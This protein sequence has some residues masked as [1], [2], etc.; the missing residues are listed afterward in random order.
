MGKWKVNGEI[1]ELENV[2]QDAPKSVLYPE[3]F[4][5]R[6]DLEVKFNAKRLQEGLKNN[7]SMQQGQQSQSNGIPTPEQLANIQHAKPRSEE[8]VE[9]YKRQVYGD[10][11]PQGGQAQPQPQAQ[12]PQ[13]QPSGIPGQGAGLPWQNQSIQ[14]QYGSFNAKARPGKGGN[15][16]DYEESPEQ[17]GKNL[18]ERQGAS[19]KGPEAALSLLPVGKFVKGGWAAKAA[20]ETA[21]QGGLAALFNPETAAKSGT[22]AA[23]T[24]GVMQ[25]L[26][27]ALSSPNKY[28]RF[29]KDQMAPSVAAYA[30][31]QKAKSSGL[32]TA[33][34]STAAAV[35]YAAAKK[36]V[37]PRLS[38]QYNAR[39]YAEELG[40]ISEEAVGKFKT[41]K[42][43]NV[44][45]T[46]AQAEGRA[47]A[48]AA[49]SRVGTSKK[50]ADL[51]QIG[52]IEQREA[53]KKAVE[54]LNKK[55]FDLETHGPKMKKAYEAVDKSTLPEDAIKEIY[56]KPRIKFNPKDIRD[57]K[58]KVK[59]EVPAK[60]EKGLYRGVYNEKTGKVEAEYINPKYKTLVPSRVTNSFR[61]NKH[62]IQKQLNHRLAKD[63]HIRDAMEKVYGSS[64]YEKELAGIPKKEWHKNGK[65]I[66]AVKKEMDE[67]IGY[68]R[69][70][71]DG[72]RISSMEDSKNKF[73]K[74]ADKSIKEY[75]LARV[76]GERQ[77]VVQTINGLT[78]KGQDHGQALSKY[79]DNSDN[80]KELIKHL[81]NV[82]GAEQ[83]VNELHDI[84]QRT[85]PV[86]EKQL[87]GAISD[88][89][90]QSSGS[91]KADLAKEFMK[92]FRSGDL[93]EAAVKL[94]LN[95][96][97]P[98]QL[99]RLK[100]VSTSSKK[101]AEFMKLL[102]RPSAG[103]VSQGIAKSKR[104][105]EKEED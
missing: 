81:R 26:S 43:Y 90:A 96:N 39:K 1:L 27:K 98:A 105:E 23:G 32:S 62:Q 50:G 11:Q 87:A 14:E 41:A 28:A 15:P 89:F 17:Y 29:A 9:Q 10:S 91:S 79:L 3:I 42:K 51:K 13:R 95:D 69:K 94:T 44:H 16:L 72:T 73:L 104:N 82:K 18:A 36:F 54:K 12:T 92:M 48:T 61:S 103:V 24:T 88:S 33:Q 64:T 53:R 31:Y 60:N 99:Q 40:P 80:K 65:F 5:I 20:A 75:K 63:P 57:T 37:N 100:R 70:H 30:A 45:L 68:E 86:T 83:H 93:D 97:W 66:N 52:E 25:L 49:E 56:K 78:K 22:S 59:L 101:L 67:M 74:E 84:F 85:K 4:K 2:P 38:N 76:L 35:A 34:A 55:T 46:P 8:E 58:P 6:P 21:Y 102:S 19:L 71:T 47:S 7:P 77:K